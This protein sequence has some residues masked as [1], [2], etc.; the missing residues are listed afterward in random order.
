[1]TLSIWR[2]SHL[3][4]ALISS[5]FLI[6]ASV[7]GLI[8]SFEP[9]QKAVLPYGTHDIEKISL[10]Q[11]I[12]VLNST[13][14]EVL[15]IEVDENDFVLASLV[16]NKGNNETI[17]IDPLT[18][19]N[20]GSPKPESAI[21]S[22]TRT[23]HRSLFLKGLGRAFVGIAS[24]LLCLIAFT[25]LLLIIKRQGG[26]LRLF[27]KV[28]KEYFEM[29]YHVVFGRWTLIPIIIVSVTGV[30]LSAEKFNLLP[31]NR[32]KHQ[33]SISETKIDLDKKPADLALLKQLNLHEVRFV[34]F[35]FSEDPEDYFEISLKDKELY[36]HQYTG[37][38][39]SEVYYPFSF[40]AKQW[41]LVLHT[42]QGSIIWS[43]VLFI[44]SISILFFIYSGFIMWRKRV[45]NTK[46]DTAATHK[47]ESTHIILVASETGS[48][49]NFAK[50]L[51]KAL[52]NAG[53]T[54]YMAHMNEYTTYNK[55]E[56]L[57][58]LAATYGH[59]ES[60][61]NARKFK[62]KF[63]TISPLNE[64]KYSVV[65]FG[66][67]QYP[68]YCAYA[69]EIDHLISK[70]DGFEET[71]PIHK[72]NNQNSIDFHRWT[73]KWSEKTGLQI[74]LENT[75]IKK[76]P[77]K[78]SIFKVVEKT[79]PNG[80]NTFL[81][82]LR[83]EK[84]PSFKSGDLAGIIPDKDGI[85]RSYSIARIKDDILLSI[86]K[87]DLGVCSNYL[88]ELKIHTKIPVYINK[89][90][91]FHFPQISP[92]VIL[93]A[94]GTGLAPFLGMLHENKK[95]IPI[96]LFLG[97]RNKKSIEIYKDELDNA[98]KSN[99]LTQLHVAYS[100]ENSNNYV[101]D[102]IKENL[103]LVLDTFST[104]GHVM[105]CGSIQMQNAV[106]DI[107]EKSTQTSLDRPL[108]EFEENGQ[109]KLDCY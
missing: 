51:K 104:G 57:I 89:N 35:P 86:K 61:S 56:H 94:N 73:K 14:D 69:I 18:G 20:L 72:I 30:Y 53:E 28:Q 27:S 65:G 67:K 76:K 106:L 47:D 60:T 85:E 100:R 46:I 93:I 103:T 59:G 1:M 83:P 81:L 36:V 95:H 52:I 11:T 99:K 90:E 87:H 77:S 84:K 55:A 42:G 5:L 44:V 66:S 8:L 64:L 102:L 33:I 23:L 17:Y 105:V 37:E 31:L 26:V 34:N 40:L 50:Q 2:Y 24:L 39:L 108:S 22:F 96:H 80:D 54:V 16:T 63:E 92:V 13:Y 74:Q 3:L 88:N 79:S 21:Y 109:L 91:K 68:N 19:G 32:L 4:L 15:S 78:P 75:I 71:L 107:I 25:G 82:K 41:S 62:S 43:I 45:N 101:Q 7:T 9:I 97:V 98:L 48:T 10:A 6:L 58:I 70:K 29:Y 49:F 12:D 38:I